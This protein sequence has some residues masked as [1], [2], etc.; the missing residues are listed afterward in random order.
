M[1]DQLEGDFDVFPRA[2][3]PLAEFR[4]IP[5]F[6]RI[7]MLGDDGSRNSLTR[8]AF[9]QLDRQTFFQIPRAASQRV[10]LLHNLQGFLGFLLRRSR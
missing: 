7:E 3:K 5:S 2:P 1:L 8:P 9:P 6:E 4:G 10:E